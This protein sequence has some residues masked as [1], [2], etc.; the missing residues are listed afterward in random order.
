MMTERGTMDDL[1]TRTNANAHLLNSEE[2]LR[3]DPATGE[4][5]QVAGWVYAAGE[6]H[7]ITVPVSDH[8]PQPE[9]PGEVH[10][11]QDITIDGSYITQCRVCGREIEL[12]Y[13]GGEM[14]RHWCCGYCYHLEIAQVDFVVTKEGK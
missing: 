8:T 14:D 5:V 13:N 7:E 12:Y 9:P 11:H 1:A 10:R 6:W 2:E 4:V 3:V